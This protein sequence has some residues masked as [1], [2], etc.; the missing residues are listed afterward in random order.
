MEMTKKIYLET[1]KSALGRSIFHYWSWP[2]TWVIFR[3]G[4]RFQ[5]FNCAL[6][7][8]EVSE[9]FFLK[10]FL[11]TNNLGRITWIL[12]LLFVEIKFQIN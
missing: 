9:D 5:T 12:K 8:H 1:L 7:T 10:K 6:S 11:L 3:R 2:C 4:G